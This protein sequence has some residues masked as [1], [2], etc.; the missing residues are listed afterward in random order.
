M[1]PTLTA[2]QQIVMAAA[3]LAAAGRTE[4]S[5]WD[6]TVAAWKR[7]RN[8][9]GCRGYE[10]QYPDHKRVM[11]EIFLTDKK[12]NP[13][14]R[15]HI[16]KVRPNYYQLTPL[17]LAEADRLGRLAGA[18]TESLRSAETLYDAVAPYVFHRV[19]LSFVRDPDEP[20]TWLAASTFL[21]LKANQPDDLRR[22]LTSV[23]QAASG[24]MDWLAGQALPSFRRGASGGGETIRL[25]DLRRLLEFVDV[26]ERRFAVQMSAIREKKG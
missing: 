22:S 6:L 23:R 17:G 10:D 13:V 9:F 25:D 14:V 12:D 20:R 21:Q 2:S 24:A 19:F 1:A 18:S 15:G 26:L 4:F 8:R 3:D 5:E 11:T 7:D 16:V